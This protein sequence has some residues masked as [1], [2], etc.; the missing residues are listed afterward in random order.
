MTGKEME[1]KS[2]SPELLR[3]ES[4]A[5]AAE[6]LIKWLAENVHPHH[7]VQ[8]T[9]THAELLQGEMVHRTE[10]FLID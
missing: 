1:T 4:F 5:K 10:Q 9:S 6:P 2:S 7:C 3:Q 8:V